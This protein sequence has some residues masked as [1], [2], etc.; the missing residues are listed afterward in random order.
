MIVWSLNFQSIS[1]NGAACGGT[2][3][4]NVTDAP[5]VAFRESSGNTP[6]PLI[7]PEKHNET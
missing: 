1:F 7:T 4:E 5:N 6:S 3:V 2:V